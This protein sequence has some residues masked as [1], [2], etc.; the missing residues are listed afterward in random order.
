M[1]S[2]TGWMWTSKDYVRE[3][4]KIQKKRNYPKYVRREDGRLEQTCK[5]GIGHTV[6]V[7]AEYQND[8]AWWVHG[9][10]GCCT[11]PDFKKANE[12]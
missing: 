10:D 9:C 6:R 4:K 5:H 8:S 11:R 3:N 2:G 7:P 1:G 12:L